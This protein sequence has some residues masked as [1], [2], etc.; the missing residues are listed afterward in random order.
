MKRMLRLNKKFRLFVLMILLVVSV[1]PL[2]SGGSKE[3]EKTIKQETSV[4]S[5]TAIGSNL[6]GEFEGPEVITDLTL[7][8]TSFQ[9]APEL[10]SLVEAGELDSV[11]ERIGKD[12]LVLKP[13]H[14]IGTY[15]GVWRRG[16]TGSGDVTNAARTVIG[17][18]GL[19]NFEYDNPTLVPNIAKDYELSKDGKVT[20]IYLREGM[21]WSDGELFTADDIMFWYEHIYLNEELVPNGFVEF[22]I[23]GK[24]GR[25][26][27]IDDYTVKFIFEDPFYSFPENLARSGWSEL[28][29]FMKGFYAPAHYLKQFHPDFISKAELDKK[30]AENSYDN[31][32]RMFKEKSNWFFNTEQPTVTPWI[33]LTTPSGSTW[34]LVR[35]PYSIW[36]DTE[37]N[38]LPYID[39]VVMTLAED[40]EILN[41]RAIAGDY[42]M[43]SRHISMSNL[44]V[45]LENQEK[46]GYKVSLD[47]GP[48]CEFA[49]T[50]NL[51]YDE[52]SE[53]TKWLNTTDFRRALSI[54][55]DRD[56]INEALWLGTGKIWNILPPPENKYYPGGD[57]GTLW[58]EY[59]VEKAN[60]MLDDLGLVKKD[61]D[62]Y[63]LR[64][65]GKGRLT[66]EITA[67][68]N[69]LIPYVDACEMVREQWKKIGIDLK[70]NSVERSLA[71]T[72]SASNKIQLG[73][74]VADGNDS[75]F[76]FPWNMLPTMS[77]PPVSQG[78][79]IGLWYETNGEK[80]VEPEPKLKN[81]LEMLAK[82][83]SVKEEERV[84]LGQEMYKLMADNVWQI[85]V[86]S[87]GSNFMGVRV[88]NVNMGNVPSRIWNSPLYMNPNNVRP[89]T[90]YF[91]NN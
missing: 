49:I 30:L 10:K 78:T 26:E 72:L 82:G 22:K 43:Q 57:Y 64:T 67:M 15:G 70:V 9:E 81:V 52:D 6:I 4:T 37:G 24:D 5:T 29:Q 63:R 62:G 68:T 88:T 59:D 76:I 90:F 7:Y 8:P 86:I 50:F 54:G 27:K 31:W 13:V 44:P 48:G 83:P 42:D 20:T 47:P 61:S 2:F 79:L 23:N 56:Q 58:T 74:W 71:L 45:L 18:D 77:Q 80:G 38:Q 34:E 89:V 73:A 39:K 46:S 3:E 87:Q 69:Q 51:T 33:N 28:G 1:N 35:N 55:I 32:V 19:L 85:G 75:I 60:K 12:P 25:V 53:I 40:S 91:K 66:I 65:D 17:R 21:R 16:F 84:K 14:E 11:E 41:L 36:V